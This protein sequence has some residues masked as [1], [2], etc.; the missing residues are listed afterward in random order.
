MFYLE[1]M[2][3]TTQTIAV[4]ENRL[5]NRRHYKLPAIDALLP[6]NPKLFVRFPLIRFSGGINDFF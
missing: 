4:Y 6:K 5:H 3:K 2:L 1:C